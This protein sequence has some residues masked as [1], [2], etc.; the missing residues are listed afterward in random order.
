MKTMNLDLQEEP[1]VIKQNS[2]MKKK[3]EKK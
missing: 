2:E 1:K 3:E